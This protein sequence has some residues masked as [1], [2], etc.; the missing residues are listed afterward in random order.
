[1]AALAASLAFSEDHMRALYLVAAAIEMFLICE[2]NINRWGL[3]DDTMINY[4]LDHDKERSE[5]IVMVPA[6]PPPLTV[7]L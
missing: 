2:F 1:M 3:R 5:C 4:N 6:L 7:V